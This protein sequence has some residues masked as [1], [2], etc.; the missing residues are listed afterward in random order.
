MF[1]SSWHKKLITFQKMGLICPKSEMRSLQ[2]SGAKPEI[3]LH[4]HFLAWKFPTG[5]KTPLLQEV[6][7]LWDSAVCLLGSSHHTMLLLCYGCLCDGAGDCWPHS[8]L[9]WCGG[10]IDPS[11]F[12]N[13][14]GK[15][16]AW[17]LEGGRKLRISPFCRTSA[18]ILS[19]FFYFLCPWFGVWTFLKREET[20][21]RNTAS[22]SE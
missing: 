18:P 13:T 14:Q 6:Q 8:P 7:K 12:L 10:R 3:S 2:S 22:K 17:P 20:R 1:S 16:K 21:R 15:R 11:C 4:T 5:R 19:F 9:H